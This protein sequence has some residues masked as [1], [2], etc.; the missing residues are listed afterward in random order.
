MNPLQL[1]RQKNQPQ[2]VELLEQH[3]TKHAI[4]FYQLPEHLSSRKLIVNPKRS[5]A[6]TVVDHAISG[7]LGTWDAD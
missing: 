2:I 7:S 6:I 3:I 5:E 1:A 4:N